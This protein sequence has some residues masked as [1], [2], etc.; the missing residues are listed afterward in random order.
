MDIGFSFLSDKHLGM[1]WLGYMIG[2][3]L[4]FK[5]L[6]N[7]FPNLYHFTLLLALHPLY[8]YI[9]IFTS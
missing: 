3:C 7:S 6:P 8:E 9:V 2:I 1:E 4:T 5:K